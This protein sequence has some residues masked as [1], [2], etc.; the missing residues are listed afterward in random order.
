MMTSLL[1]RSRRS[2][3]GSHL[4]KIQQLSNT[5]VV[6]RVISCLSGPREVQGHTQNLLLNSH[7]DNMLF[8]SDGEETLIGPDKLRITG[9]LTSHLQLLLPP[10]SV[11]VCTFVCVE[12]FGFGKTKL[13]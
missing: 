8:R 10:L 6:V 1:G 11:D 12:F 5:E 13:L 3:P 2:L 7:N 4:K 9:T